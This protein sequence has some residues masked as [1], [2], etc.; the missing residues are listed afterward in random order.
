MKEGKNNL[1]RRLTHAVKSPEVGKGSPVRL[2]IKHVIL[3]PPRYNGW[4]GK[5]RVLCY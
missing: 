3:V 4:L 2:S 1:T 5:H